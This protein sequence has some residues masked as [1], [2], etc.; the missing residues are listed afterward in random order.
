M[1]LPNTDNSRAL[2]RQRSPLRLEERPRAPEGE[3][4]TAILRSLRRHVR[5]I[6]AT[7]LVGTVVAIGAAFTITSQ[8]K[9]EVTVLVDPRKTQLLKDRDVLGTPG[10]GTDNA[11]VESEA[12]ML[13]SAALA[14]RVVER[15]NLAND[16][17]FARPGLLGQIKGIV[18]AP[19]RALFSDAAEKDPLAPVTEALQKKVEA[20]RRGLTYVVELAVWSRDS[21]KAARIAN[22]F[23]ELYLVDQVANKGHAAEQ[24][25]KWLAER[26]DDLRKRVTA[27]ERAYEQYKAESGLFDPGGENLSNRQVA[28]L[29]E[30]LVTARARAA[31]AKAKFEQLKQITPDKLE[32]AAASVD[33]LQSGVVAGL[34][35]QYAE[36][37]KKQAELGAR[38]GSGHPQVAIVRAQLH[39]ISKQITAEISRIVASAKSEYE[40]ARSR[41]ASLEA[42]LDDLKNRAGEFNQ[43]SIRLRELERE[44]QANRDLFQAFLSRAKETAAQTDVQVPDSRVVSKATPPVNTSFPPKGLLVGLGFFGS[45]GLGMALALGRDALGKGFHSVEEI[46]TSLGLQPLASLPL[47]DEGRA[48]PRH[49]KLG[50]ISM[51]Q[52]ATQGT[53]H[54]ARNSA[55]E[56]ARIS[57]RLASL[58][59][60][61]PH[62]AFAESIRSLRFA[63]SHLAA[64]QRMVTVLVT[65]ALA[66]EGKSTVA[67]N[68]ARVA[69]MAGDRVL[70]IDGDLRSPTLA[71]ALDVDPAIGL[72]ELL[73][74]RGDLEAAVR[75]DPRTELYVISG[76]KRQAGPQALATLSSSGLDKLLT[77][78]RQTFDLVV[79]DSSPLLPI[80]DG[81]ILVDR[82]DGVVLVVAS[83]QTSRD[84]VAAALHETPGIDEKLVGVVLN[85]AAE[86]FDRYYRERDPVSVSEAA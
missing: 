15:L 53:Q 22:T 34:R 50:D 59:L 45:L 71:A 26:V 47:V 64:E 74:G 30:E 43:A 81:R 58:A 3:A 83:E 48:R 21:A 84:A 78:A 36:A 77:L 67:A 32:S 63:L 10:P 9:A 12:E 72:A 66:G 86:D 14:R 39:D 75:K 38:Y 73:T 23:A 85:R 2:A 40:I 41:Q 55:E 46:E 1:L 4:V 79:I 6:A 29:N 11:V 17:E 16:E 37:A 76:S 20:K 65:S 5:L 69:A 31:E 51:L 42:S 54:A 7:A 62:S 44:A 13:K 49:Q 18:L 61:E 82:V 24:A 25:N 56:R 52:R 57:R 8:Y 80:A 60:D 19:V 35:G 33:V 68:L 28:K 27:S 70:L